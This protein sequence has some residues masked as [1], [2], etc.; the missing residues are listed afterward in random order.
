MQYRLCTSVQ[1][2]PVNDPNSQTIPAKIH[3]NLQLALL[4]HKSIILS[5]NRSNE[6]YYACRKS[7]LLLES[8]ETN[9]ENGKPN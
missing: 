2:L 7:A 3:K 6:F 8:P 5:V 1:V 4:G 9:M